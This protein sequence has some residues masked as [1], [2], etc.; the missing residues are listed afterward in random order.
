MSDVNEV[1]F[2]HKLI[3]NEQQQKRKH[4]ELLWNSRKIC[5]TDQYVKN[6]NY[7]KVNLELPFPKEVDVASYLNNHKLLGIFFDKN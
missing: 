4:G 1:K 2:A 7:F 3:G 5:K 6:R